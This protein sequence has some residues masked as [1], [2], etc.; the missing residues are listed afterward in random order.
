MAEKINH[1]YNNT[2]KEGW[3]LLGIAAVI[4]IVL[5]VRMYAALAPE[6]EKAE[7]ALLE[8]R[9]VKLDG[10][11]EEDLLKKIIADGNYY[12]DAA[13]IDLLADSLSQ[14]LRDGHRLDNMGALNKSAFAVDAPLLWNTNTGG[15]D[16]RERLIASRQRLG[17]DSALYINQLSKPASHPS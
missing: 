4:L 5:F 7:T 3:M 16:F 13:D 2:R 17:F 15:T 1:T 11:I 8:Y 6:L 10:A 12:T 14:K 9:A